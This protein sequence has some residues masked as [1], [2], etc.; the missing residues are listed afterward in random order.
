MFV[1]LTES[2]AVKRVPVGPQGVD[3]GPAVG[4]DAIQQAEFGGGTP[5]VPHAD[6]D[7]DIRQAALPPAVTQSS[8]QHLCSGFSVTGK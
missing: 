6:V 1:G 8:L 7:A 3:R 4:D 5:N 2:Q